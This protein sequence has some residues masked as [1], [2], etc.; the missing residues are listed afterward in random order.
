MYMSTEGAAICMVVYP[1]R[2]LKG[3]AKIDA[4]NCLPYSAGSSWE[5]I[6]GFG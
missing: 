1:G 2:R 3:L 5:T 4:L 6:M